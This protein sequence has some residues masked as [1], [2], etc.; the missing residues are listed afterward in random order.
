VRRVRGEIGPVEGESD[1]VRAGRWEDVGELGAEEGEVRA[2][3]IPNRSNIRCNPALVSSSSSG[4]LTSTSTFSSALGVYI[5]TLR[6]DSVLLMDRI[7]VSVLKAE[8]GWGRLKAVTRGN[9]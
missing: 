1:G 2:G 9:G 7:V 8:K 3:W 5:S 4:S 6:S